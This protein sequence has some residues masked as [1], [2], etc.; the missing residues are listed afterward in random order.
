[1]PIISSYTLDILSSSVFK[2]SGQIL[3][4]TI[5]M[6]NNLL[7]MK[8]PL[9]VASNA[10]FTPFQLSSLTKQKIKIKA[11]PIKD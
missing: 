7:K 11:N 2:F 10:S 3:Q 8:L 9:T 4:K 1:M 6:G 5:M